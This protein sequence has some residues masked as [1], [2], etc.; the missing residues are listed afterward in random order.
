MTGFE[1]KKSSVGRDFVRAFAA[2]VKAL[3]DRRFDGLHLPVIMFDGV[4]YAG[5]TMIVALGITA[6]GTKRTLGL[7]QGATENAT[8]CVA[9]LEDLQVRGLD[10]SQPLLLVLDGA[11]ALHAGAQRVWG[12][13]GVIQRCQVH[14]KRNVKAHVSEKHHAEL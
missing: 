1:A 13:D 3:A 11:K 2:Q 5:E 8:V 6:D 14:K 7:R 10:T 12:Q 9:L 4:E